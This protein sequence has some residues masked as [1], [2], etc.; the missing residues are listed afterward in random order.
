MSIFNNEGRVI[1]FLVS[2]KQQFKKVVLGNL[3]P[4]CD[5]IYL[6]KYTDFE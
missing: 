3:I 4:K 2:A 1:I 5:C 6:K